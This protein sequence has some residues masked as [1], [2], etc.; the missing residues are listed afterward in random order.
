MAVQQKECGCKGVRSCILC[1]GV[2]GGKSCGVES[3]VLLVEPHSIFIQCLICGELLKKAETRGH[4]TCTPQVTLR[5][6]LPLPGDSRFD[7]VSIIQEFVSK[8]QE[9]TLIEAI[10]RQP[11]AESQSGRRKQVGGWKTLQE[12]WWV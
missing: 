12:I 4:V 9:Q 10:D 6:V 1:E 2:D 7:G 11:W 3:P 8:E 5:P